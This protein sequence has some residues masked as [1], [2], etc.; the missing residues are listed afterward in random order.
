MFIEIFFLITE[1]WNGEEL[2][3]LVY[4]YHR[5]LLSKKKKKKAILL[6]IT[7]IN[8]IVILP[9]ENRL[10]SYGCI[11]PFIKIHELSQM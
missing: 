11:L 6:H 9:S 10:I 2:N 3:K 1:K 4:P 8:I 5:V 7:W